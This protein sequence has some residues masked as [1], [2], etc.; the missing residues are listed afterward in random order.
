M[1]IN[2]NSSVPLYL[3]LFM[4]SI[5]LSSIPVAAQEKKDTLR[6]TRVVLGSQSKPS[7]PG[8]DQ[9]AIIPLIEVTRVRDYE[10]FTF[11]ARD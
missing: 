6:E 8:S 2:W 7:Y 11:V 3:L 10:D 4:L 1:M 5:C 9:L